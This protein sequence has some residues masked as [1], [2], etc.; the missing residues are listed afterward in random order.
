MSKVMVVDDSQFIR[1]HLTKLLTEHEYEVIEV[2]N[3]EEAVQTYRQ[4]YPDAVLMDIVMPV[5]NGSDALREILSLD[6]QAKIIILSTMNQ[7]SIVLRAMQ[8]GAKDFLTKPADAKQLLKALH[9]MLRPI[10]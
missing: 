8:A 3:G 4:L 10:L 2:E 9:K 6:P 7:D 5:K 1:L